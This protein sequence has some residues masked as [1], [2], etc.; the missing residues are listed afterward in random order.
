MSRLL[1]L[2]T[3]EVSLRYMVPL[4]AMP[5][6]CAACDPPASSPSTAAAPSA[7]LPSTNT[8]VSTGSGADSPKPRGS[9]TS[10]GPAVSP[11]SSAEVDEGKG[12]AK[13]NNAFAL[14]LYERVRTSK[15]NLAFSPFSLAT[16]LAMTWG[17]A[18]A[19][20]AAQMKKV[21]HLEGT[22]EGAFSIA[23]KLVTSLC[24]P[25]QETV[26]RIANR[27]FGGKAY[28]FEPAYLDQVH[29][30]F[31]A[32]IE[33]LDFEHAAEDSRKHINQ[34]VAGETQDRIKDLIPP[35][36]IQ[37]DTR[38]VITNAIYFL[39]D[40]R[41]PFLK[42]ATNPADFYTQ[43]A[44]TKK[45]LTMHQEEVFAFA[46]TDGV[47]LLE[48][49]YEGGAL[50]MTLVL[51][52]PIDGL[53][54]VERRLSTKALDAWIAAMRSVRVRVSLPK[55]EIDPAESLA[56]KDKLEALGMSLAFDRDKADFTG[57]A[58]PPTP[59]DRLCIGQVFH[60]AF[61]KL[62]EKG[63][64][65]AA[66]TAVIAVAATAAPQRSAPPPPPEFKADHPFLFLLR[67]TRSG[68]ILFIGRV[69]DPGEKGLTGHGSAP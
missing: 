19:E 57:I 8:S 2:A 28:G 27:L 58:N 14:D 31:G 3:L 41:T 53:E 64:E 65:A 48:M 59:D 10:E 38:L 46:A 22:P 62:D 37:P 69:L 42:E 16:A 35:D 33:S 32:A 61:V 50:A 68:A 45:V 6:A 26:L 17:G 60:K 4:L 56:L 67:D 21:L 12:F 7:D 66:A 24:D 36:G 5:L 49:P 18:R 54:A 11:P 52:D 25:R 43:K 40:W 23:G 39:G 9:A 34:W 44:Q 1:K 55:F 13:S 29:N 30:A 63:T 20:T 47:K 15:G 51:P